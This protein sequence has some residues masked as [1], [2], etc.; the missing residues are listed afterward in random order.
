MTLSAELTKK[1]AALKQQL[2]ELGEMLVAFSGGVDSVLLAKVAHDVVGDKALA[3]T[4]VSESY[5]GRE[6]RDAK[7]LAADIG[8]PLR[9]VRAHELEDE[10][11][12][13]NAPNRCYFCKTE[14][15][16]Q[17]RAVSEDTGVRTV[18]YGANLDD[19]GDYRPGMQAAD[20]WGVYAP[21][22]DAQL[23]KEDIRVLS[24]MLDLRT[25]DKPAFACL[26]SRFPHG[27]RI[28]PEKLS[29][30]D[31]AEDLLYDLGFRQF[32]VRHHEDAQQNWSVARIEVPVE[33]MQRFF[34]GDTRDRVVDEF[35]GLGYG[36]VSLDLRG[37]KSGS[38]NPNLL[39][40]ESLAP[41][42]RPS[43]G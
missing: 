2:A 10:N 41:P 25:W 21:L 39:T 33:E 37:Y 3:V 34:E 12:A 35:R 11:Y 13:K 32:R 42:S 19:T 6:L 28:T 7:E 38:L 36:F 18:V 30:V 15:F 4:A 20:E 1:Y 16:T 5:P 23:T 43:V 31:A 22:L 27:T 26:S 29:Q 17:L 8:I 9:I 40:I 14:L 24:R